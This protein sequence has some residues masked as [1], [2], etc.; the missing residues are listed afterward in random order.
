[1]SQTSR[2]PAVAQ[3]LETA[4]SER[5]VLHREIGQ[6]ALDA[7]EGVRGADKRLADLR[8]KIA[9]ADREVD[10]LEKAHALAL[11]LDRQKAA[12]AVIDMRAEQ[13]AEF[14]VRVQARDGAMAKVM[15]ALAV[16]AKAYGEF[17][18]ATLAAQIAV[19]IGTTAP[20]VG[21]GKNGVLGP[22]FG[23]CEG[24][25]LAELWRLGPARKD[26]VGRFVVPFAKASPFMTSSD[27]R[28][29][30]AGIEE[31]RKADQVVMAEIE[32]QIERMNSAVLRDVEEKAAAA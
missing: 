10:E 19:P 27:H 14:T 29:L 31:F 4:I 28:D 5:A 16:V 15:E 7:A 13:M 12:T 3:K 17:S 20:Q 21:M 9:A 1:M 23:P 18:E 30:S 22:S 25:L 32:K 24:L 8:V 26:G 6:A 11:H 2:A